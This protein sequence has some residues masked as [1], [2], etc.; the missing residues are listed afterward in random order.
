MR[1][2]L[3]PGSQFCQCPTCARVFLN[4]SVFDK[5]RAGPASARKCLP[6]DSVGLIRDHRGIWRPPKRNPP[7]FASRG[8]SDK[9]MDRADGPTATEAV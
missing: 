1:K 7:Q 3:R 6:P 9:A 2:L 4:V 5:H 8:R